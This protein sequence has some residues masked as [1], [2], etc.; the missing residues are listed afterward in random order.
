MLLDTGADVN[1]QA[2]NGIT[3]LMLATLLNA[4]EIA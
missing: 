4:T 1:C 3:A 2:N